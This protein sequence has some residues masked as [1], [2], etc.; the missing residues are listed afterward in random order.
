MC[1]GNSNGGAAGNS[2]SLAT[3]RSGYTVTA[4]TNQDSAAATVTNYY[5]GATA[6]TL[7]KRTNIYCRILTSS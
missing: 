7:E 4:T 5:T 2:V 1:S 6:F 3:Q